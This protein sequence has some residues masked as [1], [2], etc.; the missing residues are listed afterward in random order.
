MS[1]FT[2]EPRGE[3][4]AVVRGTGRL[5]AVAAPAFRALVTEATASGLTRIAV[6]LSEISFIDS[7][8]LGALVGA[9]KTTRQAGGDLRIAAPTAQVVMVLELSNMDRVFRR[10]ESADDALVFGAVGGSGG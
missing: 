9:L 6:D 10:Y 2:I 7:T 8:G 1:Q 4:R 3:G 5:N